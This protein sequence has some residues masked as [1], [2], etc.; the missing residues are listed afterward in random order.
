MKTPKSNYQ[1]IQTLF[2]VCTFLF[3]L[4]SC[5]SE[6]ETLE[7]SEVNEL[8]N[9]KLLNSDAFDS[10]ALEN[11]SSLSSKSDKNKGKSFSEGEGWA[12]GKS[13][14]IELPNF[15]R[16]QKDVHQVQNY[17]VKFMNGQLNGSFEVFD[18]DENS[19][20][21]QQIKGTVLNVVF[22]DDCKTVRY[23]GTI[24]SS[25]FDAD[26]IG[27]YAFWTSVDNGVHKNDDETT[28]I[29]FG[30][31]EFAAKYHATR[32]FPT[33][34]FGPGVFQN[35]AGNVKVKSKKCE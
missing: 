18:Y 33:G 27:T 21:I 11:A 13:I 4:N 24:T 17:D 22:E 26:L 16:Y 23:T 30:M 15:Y 6:D 34:M 1:I 35:T 14:Q 32:G 29:R 10:Y 5:T 20:L 12:R 9:A 25:Q 7:L 2:F 3:S 19:E 28:D 31:S 8:N